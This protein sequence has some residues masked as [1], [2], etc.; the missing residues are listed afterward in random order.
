MHNITPH[1][2]ARQSKEELWNSIT[3]GIGIPI[4]IAG[5]TLLII[6]AIDR[7]S[8]TYWVA[9]LVYGFSM[10]WTYITSTV[11]H[12]FHK[13]RP[14]VRH[15][16]NLLDHT[17]IYLFIAG[18]YTPIALFVLSGWWSTVIL[19]SVWTLALGGIVYKLFFLGRYRKL[20]L[21]IYIAMGWLIVIAFKPF[22]E[23]APS[24][25]LIWILAG[26]IAYTLGTIFFSLQ[27]MRYAHSVWHVLVLIGTIC[28]FVGIYLYV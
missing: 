14:G 4:A 1:K 7:E 25:L 6:N 24:G 12:I 16:L 3:H 18:T 11:Y 2:A 22:Y 19:I 5:I 8:L 20:S 21:A 13:V 15:Y 27:K 23:S 28:H 10:L 17:A 26:G 9:A